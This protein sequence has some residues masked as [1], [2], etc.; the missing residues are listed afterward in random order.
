[1]SFF[2]H[3]QPNQH[4]KK[5]QKGHCPMKKNGGSGVRIGH[6]ASRLVGNILT[7]R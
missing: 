6:E 2:S 7:V 5:N 1:M 4:G 3:D